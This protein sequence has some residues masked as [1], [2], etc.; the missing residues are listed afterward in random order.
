MAFEITKLDVDQIE[1]LSISGGTG[2]SG[3]SGYSGLTGS[4]GVSGEQGFSGYSGTSGYSGSTASL[5]T[6]NPNDVLVYVPA[7]GGWVAK[8]VIDILN[9]SEVP[10][11]TTEQTY[12]KRVDFYSSSAVTGDII[13]KGEATIGTADASALWRVAKLTINI[14]GDVVEQYAGGNGN[15]ENVWNDRATLTYS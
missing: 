3:Y 15:F 13:F 14:D 1:N 9:E 12:T 4:P 11:I 5:G 8:S 2:V 7:S 10:V 6:G